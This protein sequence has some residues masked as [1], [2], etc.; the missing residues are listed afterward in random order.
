MTYI[1]YTGKRDP[2]K[3]GKNYRKRPIIRSWKSGTWVLQWIKIKFKTLI[4]SVCSL[5]LKRN[6]E[7]EKREKPK[8]ER[9]KF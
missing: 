3:R 8:T 4:K 6:R 7:T 9:T 2:R 1:D 5:N